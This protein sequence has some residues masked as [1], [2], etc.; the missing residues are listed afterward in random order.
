MCDAILRRDGEVAG[1]ARYERDKPQEPRCFLARD[2]Q[3]TIGLLAFISGKADSEAHGELRVP[4]HP[5]YE[6]AREGVP[7]GTREELRPWSAAMIKA[8]EPSNAALTT[9]I[10][11]VTTGTRPIGCVI[12]PVEEDVT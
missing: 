12:W 5:R 9:Y 4:V 11:E 1:D 6:A 3:S 2:A 8:L 10:E 7:V